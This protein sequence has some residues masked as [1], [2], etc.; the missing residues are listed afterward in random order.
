MKLDI[1][2]IKFLISEIKESIADIKKYSGIP[3]EEFFKDR[4][5]ILA[6]EHLLLRAIE[7]TADVCLHLTARI[8]HRGAESPAECFEILEKEG[9]ISKDLSS[10]LRKMARFRNLLVHRY[11]EINEKK[12]LKY[13]KEN[14]S[15]FE[16]FIKAIS[17]LI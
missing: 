6:V 10:S 1:K 16:K 2:K 11:W 4:R 3:E 9:L 15:D 14:L 17:K 8:L 5:N 12:V 13:V 7:A